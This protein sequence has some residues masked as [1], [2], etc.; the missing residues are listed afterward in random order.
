MS[1]PLKV[2]TTLLAGG[3]TLSLSG[4]ITGKHDSYRDSPYR[5]D[6]NDY[7]TSRYGARP[8][9]TFDLIN[10]PTGFAIDRLK[11]RGFNQK[12]GVSKMP[13]YT[14]TYWF[15]SKTNQCIEMRSFGGK[16]RQ[17][18]KKPFEDCKNAPAG[19]NYGNPNH[20]SGGRFPNV[21]KSAKAACIKRFN[22]SN[23]EKIKTINPLKPGFW[24]IIVKGKNGKDVACTVD[25]FGAISHW[26][27]M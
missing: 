13:D 26:V 27:P 4:C 3:L 20:R 2:S 14:L 23:F 17:F 24:E 6:S 22:S 8:V 7:N 15:N 25:Q 11:A 10:Q 16:A 12:G 18:N 1:R 9:Q 5:G 19:G 21:P